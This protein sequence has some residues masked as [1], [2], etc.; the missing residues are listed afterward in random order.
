MQ[1]KS[2][3]HLSMNSAATTTAQTTAEDKIKVLYDGECPICLYEIQWLE[4][5]AEKRGI[6]DLEFIDVADKDYT[7]DKCAGI[8]YEKGMEVMH[9]VGKDGTI[10]DSVSAFEVLYG[11]VGLSWLA[12]AL[13]NPSFQ[14][15]ANP[16]YDFWAKLRLPLTGRPS[17]E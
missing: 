14:K 11:A 5:R 10:H 2:A 16:V 12:N 4:K 3:R 9:V 1:L 13:G 6:T 17:L 15:V 7:P 8:S